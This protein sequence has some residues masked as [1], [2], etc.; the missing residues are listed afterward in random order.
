MAALTL[1]EKLDQ[2]GTRYDELT[3]ELSS[4]EIVSDSSRFQKIAKQQSEPAPEA[5]KPRSLPRSSSACIPATRRRRA[6]KSKSSQAL[7]LRSAAS[8]KSS[9]RFKGKRFIPN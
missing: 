4:A 1:S 6:G 8:R 9:P 2:L 5:M 7:L 3:H